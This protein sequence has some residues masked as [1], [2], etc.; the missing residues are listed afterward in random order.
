MSI[1]TGEIRE[2]LTCSIISADKG[3]ILIPISVSCKSRGSTKHIVF[4]HPVPTSIMTSLPHRIFFAASSCHWKGCFP[5]IWKAFSERTDRSTSSSL[6]FL[7][8]ERAEGMLGSNSW[9][10]KILFSRC[11]KHWGH[12]C[13]LCRLYQSL[14]SNDQYPPLARN[15][16][17]F[18]LG[19]AV[20][21]TKKNHYLEAWRL[22]FTYVCIIWP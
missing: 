7:T 3:E 2:W 17:W 13:T 18:A 22:Y 12:G 4:P 15:V 20:Q 10:H 14:F 11:M 9:I 21:K 6:Y 16:S 1:T 19:A 5:K 8:W